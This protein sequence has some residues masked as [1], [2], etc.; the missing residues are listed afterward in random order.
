M[1]LF[2]IILP[3][4]SLTSAWL[5]LLLDP[6]L[7]SRLC[8]L[9][10]QAAFVVWLLEKCDLQHLCDPFSLKTSLEEVY[11]LLADNGVHLPS[12][13]TLAGVDLAK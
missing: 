2:A 4:G 9:F 10:A 7:H 8:S 5:A 1:Q 6:R 11:S 13:L 3:A 12:A